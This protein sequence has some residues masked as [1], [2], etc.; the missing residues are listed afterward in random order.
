MSPLADTLAKISF[1]LTAVVLFIIY[2]IFAWRLRKESNDES[3]TKIY[4][5]STAN[6]IKYTTLVVA[7]FMLTNKVFSAQYMAWLCPLIPLIAGGTP[8]LISGLFMV[9]AI[10]T[11]YVYPYNYISFELGHSLPV[12]ILLLRNLILIITTV[13]IAWPSNIKD[14]LYQSPGK[15]ALRSGG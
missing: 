11:Q 10:L 8:Y 5:V 7:V 9:A 6:L 14:R 4:E 12:S 2:G 13:L 3:M 1:P 15:R